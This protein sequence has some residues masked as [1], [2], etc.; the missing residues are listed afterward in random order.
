MPSSPSY[1]LPDTPFPVLALRSGAL[2]PGTVQTIPVGRRSSLELAR[3][4]ESGSFL[5]VATQRDRSDE[6]PSPDDLHPVATLARVRR[7]VEVSTGRLR[8]QLDGL[9]RVTLGVFEQEAPFFRARAELTADEPGDSGTVQA[10]YA[11][12]KGAV[13]AL[14][15]PRRSGLGRLLQT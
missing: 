9:Q 12:L 15:P 2:F 6:R 4:L 8:L 11:G 5:V 14:K 3:S 7:I 10:L 13:E 1:T